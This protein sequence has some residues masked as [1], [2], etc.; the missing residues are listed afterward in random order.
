MLL[1]RLLVC[2]PVLFGFGLDACRRPFLGQF[3]I[4]III[5]IVCGCAGFCGFTFVGAGRPSF[6]SRHGTGVNRQ[7]FPTG[8]NVPITNWLLVLVQIT[9]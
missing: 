2:L 1:G 7:G 5:I 8:V 6:G 9:S 4:I 3:I